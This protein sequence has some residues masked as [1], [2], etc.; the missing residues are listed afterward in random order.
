MHGDWPQ[1]SVEVILASNFPWDSAL[2]DRILNSQLF[3]R[4]SQGKSS[5]KAAGQDFPRR[6]WICVRLTWSSTSPRCLTRTVFEGSCLHRVGLRTMPP[7][8][9]YFNNTNR[10]PQPGLQ[11]VTLVT[12]ASFVQLAALCR[13]GHHRHTWEPVSVRICFFYETVCPSDP[14]NRSGS[15]TVAPTYTQPLVKTVTVTTTVTTTPIIYC[16][17]CYPPAYV[18]SHNPLSVANTNSIW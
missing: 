9:S 15:I 1:R 16:P 8:I 6:S 4:T 18:L 3:H 17:P 11:T 2:S 13:S 12:D 14:S 7:L 5:H 10:S